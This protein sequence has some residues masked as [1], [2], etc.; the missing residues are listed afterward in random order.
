MG[1]NAKAFGSISFSFVI[2]GYGDEELKKSCRKT[3]EAGR[4]PVPYT[5][6][7]LFSARYASV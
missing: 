5:P 2:F 1:S 6:S 7:F 4:I 3:S